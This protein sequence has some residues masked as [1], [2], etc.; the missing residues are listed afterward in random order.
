MNAYVLLK[1]VHILSSTLLFGT[2]LGTAFFLW[3]THRSNQLPAIVVATRLTVRAD[4]LFTTPAVIVQP[5]SGYLLM[6]LM[7]FGLHTPWLQAA[8]ALYLLAGACWL[9]V[10]WLQWRA[11]NLAAAALRDGT[12]PPPAYHRCMRAWFAL[13]WPAF[14]AVATTFWLMV[15]KPPLWG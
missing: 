4:L 9:P 13:G 5:V 15:A 7:G 10:V 6:R 14:L 1:T 8:I 2:G 3:F 11:R 12:E